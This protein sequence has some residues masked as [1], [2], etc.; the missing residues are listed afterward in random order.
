[1][2]KQLYQAPSAYAYHIIGKSMIT[3]SIRIGN[4]QE[5]VSNSQDIGFV[6][7]EN[8]LSGGNN[9]WDNEW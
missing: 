2:K 8:P 6:K 3:Q 1:M 5:K 7:E 4:T 9:L